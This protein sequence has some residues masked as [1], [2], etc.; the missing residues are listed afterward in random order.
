MK[1]FHKAVNEYLK[2]KN[3]LNC[4]NTNLVFDPGINDYIV[5]INWSK[6]YLTNNYHFI[7]VY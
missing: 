7:N 4:K 3:K 5:F 1:K 2:F 6:E